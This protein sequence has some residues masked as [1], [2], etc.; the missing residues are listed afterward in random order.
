[1][2]KTQQ[3]WANQHV[4]LCEQVELPL[5]K[6]FSDDWF[7]QNVAC[8]IF[9]V[10]T[11][12][13]WRKTWQLHLRE[14]WESAERS[15]AKA[16]TSEEVPGPQPAQLSTRIA[17][18]DQRKKRHFMQAFCFLRSCQWWRID[19]EQLKTCAAKDMHFQVE[20]LKSV[21]NCHFVPL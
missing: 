7:P 9:S 6:A 11:C 8:V 17:H 1:M 15:E 21:F 2:Q 5:Q 12:K 3:E 20:S 18:L 4:L 16:T 14:W 13:F 19:S 10:L